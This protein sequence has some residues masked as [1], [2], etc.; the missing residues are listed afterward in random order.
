M[1]LSYLLSPSREEC[2]LAFEITKS[3]ILEN[4]LIN[5]LIKEIKSAA[6]D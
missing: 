1:E 5:Y 2:N 4:R 6:C 3:V